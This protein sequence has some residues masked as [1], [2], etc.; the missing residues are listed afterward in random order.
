ML[1][2]ISTLGISVFGDCDLGGLSDVKG[3]N[4]SGF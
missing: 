1:S 3:F 4:L 2:D